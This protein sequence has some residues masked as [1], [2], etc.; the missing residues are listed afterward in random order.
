[1]DNNKNKKRNE[2]KWKLEKCKSSFKRIPCEFN[3][4]KVSHFIKETKWKLSVCLFVVS[5]WFGT[6]DGINVV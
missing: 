5:V 6:A 1:M 3:K 4:L 2:N